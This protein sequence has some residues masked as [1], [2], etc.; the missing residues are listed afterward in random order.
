[1]V[2]SMEANGLGDGKGE[3]GS[4]WKEDCGL[5]PREM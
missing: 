2:L 3:D 4:W 1:V 5:C